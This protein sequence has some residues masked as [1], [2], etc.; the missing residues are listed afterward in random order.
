MFEE[1]SLIQGNSKNLSDLVIIVLFIWRKI[2]I[3][4]YAAYSIFTA[5]HSMKYSEIQKSVARS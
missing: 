4:P 5:P 2:L 3:R 1:F